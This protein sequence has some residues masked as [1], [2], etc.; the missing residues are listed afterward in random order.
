MA[1]PILLRA[2]PGETGLSRPGLIYLPDPEDSDAQAVLAYFEDHGFQVLQ[3]PCPDIHAYEHAH[4]GTV[5][6][7]ADLPPE[8]F[9]DGRIVLA[10]WTQPA[11]TAPASVASPAAQWLRDALTTSGRTPVDA[12]PDSPRPTRDS[13]SSALASSAPVGRLR[14]DPPDVELIVLPPSHLSSPWIPSNEVRH[15]WRGSTIGIGSPIRVPRR[16]PPFRMVFLLSFLGSLLKIPMASTTQRGFPRV[17]KS[18]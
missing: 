7:L 9:R 1:P 11:T 4:P 15:S 14:F 6:H 17:L 8:V 2:E 3:D 16:T 18:V 12:P 13:L 10:T 5:V